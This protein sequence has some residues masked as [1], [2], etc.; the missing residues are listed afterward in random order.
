MIATLVVRVAESSPLIS[1]LIKRGAGI[2]QK[3]SNSGAFLVGSLGLHPNHLEVAGFL[4]PGAAAYVDALANAAVSKMA[5]AEDEAEYNARKNPFCTQSDIDLAR[6]EARLNLSDPET[7]MSPDLFT[8]NA[9]INSVSD[10][11]ANPQT[12]V[13]AMMTNFDMAH[14][15]MA[16]AGFLS[17]NE[18]GFSVAGV[19][20]AAS[21]SCT[22]L[23]HGINEVVSLSASFDVGNPLDSV[24]VPHIVGD[25]PSLV[26]SGLQSAAAAMNINGLANVSA[27]LAKG[28]FLGDVHS[29]LK[30]AIFSSFQNM[31]ANVPVELSKVEQGDD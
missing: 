25:V 20:M 31:P 17:G 4:K 18:S 11:I 5:D 8:G 19:I 28:G 12:Q 1:A 14:I 21:N 15:G 13:G 30:D 6:L 22:R 7:I 9:G 3:S 27:I 24:S 26:T 23:E 29:A 2:L 16:Q 10:L